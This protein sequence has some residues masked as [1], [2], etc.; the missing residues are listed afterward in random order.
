MKYISPPVVYQGLRLDI[1]VN[2]KWTQDWKT[3]KDMPFEDVRIDGERLNF[4]GIYDE[5][6]KLNPNQMNIVRGYV[7]S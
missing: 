6:S 5:T 3:N 7:G 4:E 2:P 1:F